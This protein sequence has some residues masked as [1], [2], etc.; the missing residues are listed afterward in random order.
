V[1][2]QTGLKPKVDTRFKRLLA[3]KWPFWYVKT[4][5]SAFQR[6]GLPD[7]LLCVRGVFLGLELKHPDAV[8]ED[9]WDLLSPRQKYEAGKIT[10]AGG[11]IEV[12]QTVEEAEWIVGQI[13]SIP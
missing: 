3:K 2:E 1:N 6:V 13:L 8:A 5:G 10:E 7:Y 9:R 4:A 12:I 11:R